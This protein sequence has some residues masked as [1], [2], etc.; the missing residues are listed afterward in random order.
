M[1]IVWVLLN[2]VLAMMPCFLHGLC[3]KTSQD[4]KLQTSRTDVSDDV[5]LHSSTY[6]SCHVVSDG[7]DANAVFL[8][9][10]M[11][12]PVGMHYSRVAFTNNL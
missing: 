8:V 6:S 2:F 1:E 12:L 4:D 5:V 7:D 3:I 10:V 9:G 11:N